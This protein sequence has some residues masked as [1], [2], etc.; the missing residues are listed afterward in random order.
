MKQHF[1]LP[2]SYITNRCPC[3]SHRVWCSSAKPY[4]AIFV[5]MVRIEPLC[6]CAL[7][8]RGFQT[9]GVMTVLRLHFAWWSSSVATHMLLTKPEQKAWGM[10]ALSWS[11]LVFS[12]VFDSV[13]LLLTIL[14]KTTF[15]FITHYYEAL[16]WRVWQHIPEPAF[17]REAVFPHLASLWTMSSRLLDT[18]SLSC[19][20]GQQS[21]RESVCGNW[22]TSWHLALGLWAILQWLAP[23][24]SATPG[25]GIKG[26]CKL[27]IPNLK[28]CN[29]SKVQNN[30]MPQVEKFS[31]DIMWWVAVKTEG[32]I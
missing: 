28:I 13:V 8:T 16:L 17:Q 21:Y 22:E 4:I 27:S 9:L 1:Y 26:K 31:P 23:N 15:G 12:A 18:G 11:F 20:Q 24:L 25:L 10:L 3:Y 6:S 32:I 19:S 5:C 2:W 14:M 29:A 30:M 7:Q